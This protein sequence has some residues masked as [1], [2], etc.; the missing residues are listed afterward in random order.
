VRGTLGFL[1][2][3]GPPL[4]CGRGPGRCARA[5]GSLP[6]RFPL[7][8]PFNPLE[9]KESWVSHAACGGGGLAGGP[10]L[11]REA[12]RRGWYGSRRSAR[13][14]ARVARPKRSDTGGRAA[15][16]QV[17]AS[18]AST[19][20]GS[21]R[22]S[23]P[24][25]GSVRGPP[26]PSRGSLPC[27]RRQPRPRWPRT[28]AAVA[29]L[30]RSRSWST[31]LARGPG[32]QVAPCL[33]RSFVLPNKFFNKKGNHLHHRLV[34]PAAA[35]GGA[36]PAGDSGG[37][38]GPSAIGAACT[39]RPV[40]ERASDAARPHPDRTTVTFWPA[41]LT[42]LSRSSAPHC[43]IATTASAAQARLPA[44]GM[45]ALSTAARPRARPGAAASARL[46]ATEA[47]GVMYGRGTATYDMAYH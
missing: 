23:G 45:M 24:A 46:T 38:E 41:R 15:S 26:P 43:S 17:I 37:P 33:T 8:R 28:E 16:T 35:G 25:T 9:I 5:A 30:R 39:I 31:N 32:R 47:S 11:L 19:A 3:Y 1:P 44:A 42:S 7:G 40:P 36:A 12:Y 13:A 14:R 27:R 10:A 2:R 29:A 22:W 4:P 34:R 21:C 6:P 18:A 20:A